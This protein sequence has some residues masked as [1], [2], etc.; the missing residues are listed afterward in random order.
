M[1]EKKWAA[2]LL[3]IALVIGGCAAP[4]K[5]SGAEH[6]VSLDI[7]PTRVASVSEAR[8]VQK[9]ADLIVSGK[10]KKYHEFFLPG[11]VD[12]VI[13]DSQGTVIAKE[14]PRLTGHASKR[15]GVK[16]GRFSA[17][18]RLVPPLGAKVC[19]KYHA[20]ASGEEHLECT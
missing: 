17:E 11:H 20:P 8:V 15:G 4:L 12:I 3:M 2:G 10:V 1:R 16:E 14:T 19:V 9:G 5:K 13:C 7:V 6:H 18:L